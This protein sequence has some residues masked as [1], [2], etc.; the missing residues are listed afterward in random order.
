MIKYSIVIPAYNME[1]YIET[2]IE[3]IEV[4]ERTDLEIV[5]VNDGSTD[6]TL[7]ICCKLQDKYDN[8]KLIEKKNTG[9]MDSYMVGVRNCIGKYICFV[10]SDDSIEK[11]YFDTID[12][13]LSDDIDILMFDYYEYGKKNKNRK[14]VNDIAYGVIS[15]A[16]MKK[17]KTD[18]F[19]SYNKY[20]F[21]RW[22][23]VYKSSLLKSCIE[24]IDFRV[25]YFEDLYIELLLLE[26]AEKILYI[27][28]CLYDY[29]IRKSSVTHSPTK[30]VFLDNRLMK[31]KLRDYML[32][33]GMSNEAIDHMSEYM[34]YGYVRYYLRSKDKPERVAITFSSVLNNAHR[35]QK[36]LLILY[37]MRLNKLF[38]LLYS[39]RNKKIDKENFFD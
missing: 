26:K 33:N 3:S 8:I 30:K 22:N 9:S 28:H 5:I 21:Y 39:L 6:N 20:S 13:Y 1:R 25:T 4:Q 29:R 2:C 14:K 27:D 19:A 36:P 16:E 18:Y 23:K 24:M 10:D 17:L 31:A 15:E 37:K 12:K 35:D 38:D 7:E 32:T 34:D 11:K